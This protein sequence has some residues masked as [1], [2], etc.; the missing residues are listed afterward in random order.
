M[1]R[2]SRV[3]ARMDE[4]QFNYGVDPITRQ[5]SQKSGRF[6]PSSH[7]AALWEYQDA[8]GATKRGHFA[9]F[10]DRGGTDQTY[11]FRGCDDGQLDLV[12]GSRLKAAKRIWK[13][14]GKHGPL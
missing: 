10:S 5:A 6:A 4:D 13:S 7:E 2:A 14:C 12:S 1:S 11:M 3:L 8:R 9:G